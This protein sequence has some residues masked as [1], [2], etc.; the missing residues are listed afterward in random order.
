MTYGV[1]VRKYRWQPF[2]SRCY[3]SWSRSRVWS[4][5]GSRRGVV[6]R[7]SHAPSSLMDETGVVLYQTVSGCCTGRTPYVRV[8][9]FE[10][11]FFG[12]G[13]FR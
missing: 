12:V 5:S 2:V 3:G 8:R 11:G 13:G 6:N 4:V 1:Q 9:S 10:G 7:S